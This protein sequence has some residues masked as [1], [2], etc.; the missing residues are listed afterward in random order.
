MQKVAPP[1]C[2][3]GKKVQ[4]IE[5]IRNAPNL[6]R[7]LPPF[8]RAIG[9]QDKVAELS[10][11]NHKQMHEQLCSL[12]GRPSDGSQETCKVYLFAHGYFRNIPNG[13]HD[14]GMK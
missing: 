10:S 5:D 1:T 8:S 9:G 11:I 12:V 2:K 3:A 13:L 4:H 14:L 7:K 6:C